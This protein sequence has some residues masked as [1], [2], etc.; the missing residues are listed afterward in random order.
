MAYP[1]SCELYQWLAAGSSPYPQIHPS[2]RPLDTGGLVEQLLDRAAAHHFVADHPE[3]RVVK[4]LRLVLR[5]R[6]E[7][8]R[9]GHQH[10]APVDEAHDV[11]MPRRDLE[12]QVQL[13][14]G[15]PSA[16][17]LDDLLEH[18]PV[19]RQDRKSTRLN[20]SHVKISYA[21]FCLKKKKKKKNTFCYKKTKKNKSQKNC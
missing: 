14:R 15:L 17:R 11:D 5:H 12:R 2:C 1:H 9:L 19:H 10:P 8:G 20:S 7:R 6:V 3:R 16:R 13:F 4:R 21:V 18:T